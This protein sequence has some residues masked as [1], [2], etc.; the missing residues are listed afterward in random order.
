M[1]AAEPE[2]LIFCDH[3]RRDIKIV[4]ELNSCKISRPLDSDKLLATF[5][6][7]NSRSKPPD[8]CRG[9]EVLAVLSCNGSMRRILAKNIIDLVP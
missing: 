4:P 5:D 3:A 1:V 9:L 8:S 6:D 2:V 7:I